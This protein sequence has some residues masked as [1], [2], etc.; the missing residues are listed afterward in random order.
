MRTRF[1]M[2]LLLTAVMSGGFASAAA[3]D[4]VPFRATF[5]TSPEIVGFCGPTCLMLE[6]GGQGVAT[7]LGRTTIAGPS[8][9]E[10]IEGVQTGTS[11]LTSADGDTLVIGF[12]GS[13]VPEGPNPDDPVNFEGTWEVIGGTGRFAE[14]IGAGAYS[15]FAAGPSGVLRLVGRVSSPSA[16]R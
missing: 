14:A 11:T 1:A 10:V 4:L 2:A 7:H 16:N 9:V 3:A 5:Q 8:Q 6:I 12:E 13:A 15:G